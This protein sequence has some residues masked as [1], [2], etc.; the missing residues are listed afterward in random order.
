MY[1]MPR[2]AILVSGIEISTFEKGS[3]IFPSKTT[4]TALA[5]GK[6]PTTVSP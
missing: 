3:F 2:P 1:K 4:R 5:R 6:L